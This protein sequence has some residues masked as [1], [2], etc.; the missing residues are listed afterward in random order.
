M[1]R[2]EIERRVRVMTGRPETQVTDVRPTRDASGKIVAYEV[3][4]R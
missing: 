4:I 2:T 1:E 3:D